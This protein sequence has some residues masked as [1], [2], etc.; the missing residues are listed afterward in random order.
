MSDDAGSSMFIYD[1]ALTSAQRKALE[2]QE[3]DITE[4]LWRH[5]V[6]DS[7]IWRTLSTT[8]GRTLQLILPAVPKP[9]VLVELPLIEVD[10][11]SSDVLLSRIENSLAGRA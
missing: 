4:A 8:N 3:P 5:D 10:T 6:S 7:P 9:R 1:P 11:I 2:E